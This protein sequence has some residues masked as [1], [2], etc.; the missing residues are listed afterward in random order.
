VNNEPAQ[1]KLPL[2]EYIN[3]EIL[4]VLPSSPPG[5]AGYLVIALAVQ[6]VMQLYWNVLRN[7]LDQIIEFNLTVLT[8][9]G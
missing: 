2:Q 6:L 4:K 8:T 5:F 1:I 9:A 7:S 3:A